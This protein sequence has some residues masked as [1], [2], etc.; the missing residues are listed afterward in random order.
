MLRPEQEQSS[1]LRG[2]CDRIAANL[3]RFRLENQP[4][5]EELPRDL[6]EVL[7]YIHEHVFDPSL[8]VG[9]VKS[10]CGIR[11]NNVST[12][13]R[14]AIGLGIREYIET[15]RL[16][17]AG[18]LLKNEE[19]EVYLVAMAVGYSYH[20]SFCRAFQRFFGCPPSEYAVRIS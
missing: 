20:E 17:A 5:A 1:R 12:R 14:H 6:R 4:L 18:H 15:L 16:R 8:N 11:N 3:E 10:R 9:T 7:K 19:L 2:K 13:F